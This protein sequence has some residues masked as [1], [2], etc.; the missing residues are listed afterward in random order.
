MKTVK[1][2]SIWVLGLAL[3]LVA[4]KYQR[5]TGPTYPYQSTVVLNGQSYDLELIRSGL[6]TEDARV[7]LPISDPDVHAVLSY[8]KYPTNDTYTDI[9]FKV[10]GEALVAKLPAQPMAGKLQY[11]VMI[12][13]SN[14]DVLIPHQVIRFKGD[15][16]VFVLLPHILLMF[17]TM[18]FSNVAG[19]MALFN[20]RQFKKVTTITLI[21]L[22]FGGMLLGPV[23]QKY[24]FN[25]FWAGVPF[26][27][28]LTDNKT[29]I[30]F[31]FWIIAFVVN[32]KSPSR[33]WTAIAAL[34]TLVIFAIPHSMFGS[35]LDPETGEIIQGSVFAMLLLF[36]IKSRRQKSAGSD[37]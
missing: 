24:A 34:V 27:W 29:L 31:V 32:R 17:I 28:D 14:S 30:A 10:E 9:P 20:F 4:A 3:T 16:P 19:F 37:L 6:T 21:T 13:S 23:V 36:R 7:V 35:E 25:E 26:G 33:L 12:Q 11:F 22:L 18:W 5:T 15:V 2:I 8:R 1:I